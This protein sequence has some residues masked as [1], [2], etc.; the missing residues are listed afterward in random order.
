MFLPPRGLPR[1][2]SGKIRRLSITRMLE[3]DLE[4]GDLSLQSK[5]CR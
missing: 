5:E 4:R 2:T 1:T 3:S